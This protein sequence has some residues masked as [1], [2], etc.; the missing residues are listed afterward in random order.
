MAGGAGNDFIDGG[1][2]R[3][4]TATYETAASGVTVNLGTPGQAENT[5]QP[6]STPC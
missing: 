4:N 3:L 5:A 6:A 2:G 1:A